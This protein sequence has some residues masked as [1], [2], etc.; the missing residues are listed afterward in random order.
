MNRY[1]TE[2]APIAADKPRQTRNMTAQEIVRYGMDHYNTTDPVVTEEGVSKVEPRN[3][4]TA[5]MMAVGAAIFDPTD[6]KNPIYAI[7]PQC[8]TEWAK[9]AI[10]WYHGAEPIESFVGVYS[11]GYAG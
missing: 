9:A 1:Q 3:K 11:Q 7:M 5:Y 2:N 4:F 10:I 6:W 8:G